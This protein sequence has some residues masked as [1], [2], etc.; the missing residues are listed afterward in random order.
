[1]PPE[2]P[3]MRSLESQNERFFG[4]SSSLNLDKNLEIIE[5]NYYGNFNLEKFLDQ[6]NDPYFFTGDFRK[7]DNYSLDSNSEII[8]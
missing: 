7:K 2:S 1:M 8:F 5:N 4:D 6:D 3:L